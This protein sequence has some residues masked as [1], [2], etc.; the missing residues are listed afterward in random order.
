MQKIKACFYKRPVLLVLLLIIFGTIII[1]NLCGVIIFRNHYLMHYKEAVSYR[2]LIISNKKETK[3]CYSYTAKVVAYCDKDSIWKDCEGKIKIYVNKKTK[4]KFALQDF[5][6]GD[7][8]ESNDN[9]TP[10]TNSKDIIF[11]YKLYMRRKRIYDNVFLYNFKLIDKNKGNFFVS[12][13]LKVNNILQNRLDE[14]SLKTKEKALAKA[15]LLGDKN[16][17]P[18]EVKQ[19]FSTAGLAHLLCVSGLHIMM[20]IGAFLYLFRF[21]GFYNE[22]SIYA[23][24]IFAVILAWIIAFIVGLTPSSI[25]IALMISILLFTKLTSLCHDKLNIFYL[26]ALIF[27]LFDPLLLYNISFELSFLSVWGILLLKD[28][29]KF[30]IERLLHKKVNVFGGKIIS[31]ICTT[32]SAQVFTLPIIIINF[33]QLPIFALL[34]NLIVVPL[35]QVI[36]ISILMLIV[37]ANIPII[38]QIIGWIC[39]IEMDFLLFVASFTDKIS[40]LLI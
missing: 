13:A 37:F 27:L 38:G 2:Y 31:N 28:K 14:S 8:I 9:I 25:R 12:K 36:L 20:I 4:E 19:S 29:I 3:K 23:K 7:L 33:K 21:I 1:D 39:N 10:I 32:T 24:N 16:E 35:M 40:N 34:C 17:L 26:T 15:M 30:W 5:Q 6:Y 11:D 22:Y 18:I